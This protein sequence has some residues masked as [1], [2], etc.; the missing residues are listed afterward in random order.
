[1]EFVMNKIISIDKDA[2]TYR[3]GIEKLLIEKEMELEKN[4]NELRQEWT[5]EEKKIREDIM[6]E[7][8]GVAEEKAKSISKEKE[9]SIELIK[10]KYAETSDQIVNEVFLK[11]INSL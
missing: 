6:N 4:I 5:I 1:M 3:Q 7:K 8:L 2:E 9:E 10:N 11:I